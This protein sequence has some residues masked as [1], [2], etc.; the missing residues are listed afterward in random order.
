MPAFYPVCLKHA[1]RK[2]N[3]VQINDNIYES[4]WQIGQGR[5]WILD[6]PGLRADD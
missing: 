6:P 5:V 4:T 1:L 2:F 3:N